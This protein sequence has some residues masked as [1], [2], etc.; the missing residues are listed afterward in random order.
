[1][2]TMKA[3]GQTFTAFEIV[4][5]E[6]LHYLPGR[7]RYYEAS[8]YSWHVNPRTGRNIIR[9]DDVNPY[10]IESVAGP[11]MF[12]D[13]PACADLIHATV[14][15]QYTSSAARCTCGSTINVYGAPKGGTYWAHALGRVE[16]APYDHA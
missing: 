9:Y 8:G 7:A 5:D 1:M 3:A 2:T 4:A 10:A 6:D 13:A 11:R 16:C 15:H 12:Q 14:E